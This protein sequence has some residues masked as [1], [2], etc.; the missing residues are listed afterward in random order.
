MK[1]LPP[2]IAIEGH[3]IKRGLT[4]VE[5]GIVLQQPLDRIMT[6]ILFSVIR[7][8]AASVKVKDP[9]T[10][11]FTDPQPPNLM[12]YEKDFLLA[13]REEKTA[14]RRKLLQDM[15]LKLVKSIT[16]KMK[17]FSYKESVAYYKDI[18]ERAWAQVE[19]AETPEVKMENYDKYMDWAMLD[20]KFERKTEDV[21]RTSGPV[22][23]PIWWS[24]YD[25]AYR[26]A[27]LGGTARVS[28]SGSG[29]GGGGGGISVSMPNLPGA[30]FAASITGGVQNFASKVVGDIT[31]FTNPITQVTN[32]PPKPS[33]SSY[34][35]GGGGGGHSCACACACAGCACA[36]AGGG[37]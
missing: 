27:G 10:L 21:F 30:T 23:V 17:G 31:S 19:T 5:A 18:M 6:M 36:C 13:F 1:Y 33:S 4:A 34:R 3:G 32:P 26:A 14:P 11:E 28:T 29:G 8:G 22:F 2:K 20:D 16:E 15:M 12:E 9:L 25:P 24:N 37:R 35:S 7:K